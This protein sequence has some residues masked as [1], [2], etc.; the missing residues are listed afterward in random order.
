MNALLEL[1]HIIQSGHCLARIRGDK[2]GATEL[3]STVQV[4]ETLH[5]VVDADVVVV[6]DVFPVFL[7]VVEYNGN[8]VVLREAVR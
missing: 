8:V 5:K 3:Q 4:S 7:G 2:M 1:G 6:A